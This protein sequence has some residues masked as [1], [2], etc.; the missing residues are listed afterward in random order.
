[1]NEQYG[2][3]KSFEHTELLSY[4]FSDG[5]IPLKIEGIIKNTINVGVLSKNQLPNGYTETFSVE[6]LPEFMYIIREYLNMGVPEHLE[7]L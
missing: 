5:E 2:K 1:M 3:H 7:N 4:R 6:D